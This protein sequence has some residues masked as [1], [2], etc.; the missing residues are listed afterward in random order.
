MTL[1]KFDCKLSKIQKNI[2]IFS[3]LSHSCLNLC[4]TLSFSPRYTFILP[5]QT[6]QLA[7]EPNGQA[8][9]AT[10][11]MCTS[12]LS[13]SL[14]VGLPLSAPQALWPFMSVAVTQ[15]RMTVEAA[16]L[17]TLSSLSPSAAALQRGYLCHCFGQQTILFSFE[18]TTLQT[19]STILQWAK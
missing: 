6:T 3:T 18:A 16:S 15:V 1:N 13:W 8:L 2:L 5:T 11:R 19:N 9:T 17:L 12:C 4:F 14:T 7:S 10:S